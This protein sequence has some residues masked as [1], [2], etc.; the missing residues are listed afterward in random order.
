MISETKITLIRYSFYYALNIA[1]PKFIRFHRQYTKP[2]FQLLKI[3]SYQYQDKYF[4][5]QNNIKH[6]DIVL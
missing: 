1:E 2:N 5:T 3:L 6:R 4:M